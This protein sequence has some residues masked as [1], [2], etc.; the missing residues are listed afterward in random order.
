M[1]TRVN[2]A[3]EVLGNPERRAEY[4]TVYFRL[5]AAMAEEERK[6][7]EAER[8]EWERR[9]R[10]RQQEL[11]RKRREAEAARRRAAEEERQRAERVRQE[12]ERQERLRRE[13]ERHEAEARRK[14]EQAR[15]RRDQE[16]QDHEARQRT[17]DRTQW[18]REQE[19]GQ[20]RPNVGRPGRTR[21]RRSLRRLGRVPFWAGIAA[22]VGLSS[23]LA[24]IVAGVVV[25]MLQS[26]DAGDQGGTSLVETAGW[27]TILATGDGSVD[28]SAHA[29]GVRN[30]AAF[31][32]SPQAE[33][34]FFTPDESVWSAGFI[35]HLS[36][37]GYSAAVVRRSGDHF[38]VVNWRRQ[39]RAEDARQE[40]RFSSD[41]LR[42]SE[43]NV[44]NTLRMEVSN[45]GGYLIMND[46]VLA[47]VPRHQL[48]P[49]P[50]SVHFCAGFFGGEPSYTVQFVGLRGTVSED[51]A[52]R[53]IVDQRQHW[54]Q[55]PT[56]A[57]QQTADA[58]LTSNGR[59]LT[60]L[61]DTG[62]GSIVALPRR[63]IDCS[64]T[65]AAFGETFVAEVD[66]PEPPGDA[67]SVGFLYHVS[68]SGY[69]SALVRRRATML[70]AAAW[71][72]IGANTIAW[73][74][75]PIDPELMR[76]ANSDQPN[77]LRIEVSET[78]TNL[79]LNDSELLQVAPRDLRPFASGVRLCAGFWDDEP[80]YAISYPSL[81]GTVGET[82]V[83]SLPTPRV[84]QVTARPMATASPTPVPSP[85]PTPP[86]PTIGITATPWPTPVPLPT[87][88][89][90]PTP[91]P[92]PAPIPTATPSPTPTS[93]PVPIPTV[94]PS[95]TPTP[96]PTPRVTP[97][98]DARL[99][100]RGSGT[101][102][103]DA[104]TLFLG[105]PIRT[106]EPAHLSSSATSGRVEFSFNVPSAS[107]WS[108][109]LVYHRA[110]SN[111]LTATYVF[112]TT[113]TGVTVG[114]ETR[115]RGE[116]AYSISETLE[117]ASS[118]IYDAVGNWNRV[119]IHTDEKGT[120]LELNGTVVL[121]VPASKLRPT[122]SRMQVCSGL[123]THEPADYAIDYV[124]LR[125]WTE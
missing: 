19:A 64:S 57:V 40:A 21:V 117:T 84:I 34:L 124:D 61:T 36:G 106:D 48:K 13:R 86:S 18:S 118:L 50:S 108:I 9:E 49:H 23:L 119:A 10:L 80:Q 87:S 114:H 83:S 33:A 110:A 90:S 51:S 71:T 24:L 58:A 35:Y 97:T 105:C 38:E 7:R 92:T 109:G 70:D 27:G 62:G 112:R 1:M 88:T 29:G 75:N 68:E 26:S 5:R 44:P 4:D 120:D 31:G 77:V 125:S 121:Q 116:V 3:W 73:Q 74:D 30:V 56:A 20:T 8:L 89:P 115:L 41:I 16:R 6:Q 46:V 52:F 79:I 67:W 113:E 102:Y 81:R 12:R 53:G 103:T 111:T 63:S 72:S 96:V 123:F 55:I 14:A 22:G 42:S 99:I 94:T 93:T 39:G 47:H 107:D 11:E 2:E 100:P 91:T 37:A 82:V 122:S 45:D 59:D 17:Y 66:V 78:G 25:L 98:P 65:V 43:S 95:P 101:L 54:P 69:S 15:A 32:Q 104:D 76:P 85:T 60:T 28:C